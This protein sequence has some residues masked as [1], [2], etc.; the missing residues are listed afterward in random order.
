MNNSY[1]K[2]NRSVYL[3]VGNSPPANICIAGD[4]LPT[5]KLDDDN[6]NDNGR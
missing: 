5:F 6:G 4:P 3:L 1:S 2:E